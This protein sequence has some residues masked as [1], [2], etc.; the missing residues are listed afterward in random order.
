MDRPGSK[1]AC[2]VNLAVGFYIVEF[3]IW[4]CL[5]YGCRAFI[6]PFKP[7]AGLVKRNRKY[8]GRGLRISTGIAGQAAETH[9]RGRHFTLQ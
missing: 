3:K 2:F 7:C 9:G 5:D 1:N 6:C 4:R 8:D